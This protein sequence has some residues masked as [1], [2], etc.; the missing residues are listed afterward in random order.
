M[1]EFFV[2]HMPPHMTLATSYDFNRPGGYAIQKYSL[3]R[4]FQDEQ[5]WA[6]YCLDLVDKFVPDNE[7]QIVVTHNTSLSDS[8][9]YMQPD[10]DLLAIKCVYKDGQPRLPWEY[11]PIVVK[12]R[13]VVVSGL[14]VE[15]TDRVLVA[16]KDAADAR[17]LAP[18]P[19]HVY[20]TV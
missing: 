9:F 5:G 2:V 6:S 3:R 4:S 11:L 14:R 1:E 13:K 8:C 16:L 15:D 7:R 10:S 18:T 17:I 19:Q 20:A 12:G